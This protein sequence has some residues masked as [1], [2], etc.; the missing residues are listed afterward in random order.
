MAGGGCSAE[1]LAAA[2]GSGGG[3]AG[4]S[5]SA[6]EQEPRRRLPVVRAGNRRLRGQQRRGRLDTSTP[7]EKFSETAPTFP[8]LNSI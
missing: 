6:G 7:S 5:V 4:G 2:A 1:S 8:F 3:A